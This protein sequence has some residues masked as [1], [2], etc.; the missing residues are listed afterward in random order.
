MGRLRYMCSSIIGALIYATIVCIWFVYN[1][2]NKGSKVMK[3]VPW[4][5][6]IFSSLVVAYLWFAFS[7]PLL[8]T[9]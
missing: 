7:I 9:N 4:D 3:S 6:I 1:V 8:Y 2:L 5:W